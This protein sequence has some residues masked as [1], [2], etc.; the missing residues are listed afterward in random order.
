[1]DDVTAMGKFQTTTGF[2]SDLDRLLQRKY[3]SGGFLY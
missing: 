2:L 1:M 3:M